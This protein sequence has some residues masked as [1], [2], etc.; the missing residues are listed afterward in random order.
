[1]FLP[2][3]NSCYTIAVPLIGYVYVPP[4]SVPTNV[5][6]AYVPPPDPQQLLAE[7]GIFLLQVFN[8]VQRQRT[9]TNFRSTL[10]S[11][12]YRDGYLY[13]AAVMG[14]RLFGTFLVSDPS[15]ASPASLP[16]VDHVPRSTCSAPLHSGSSAI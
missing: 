6:P 3:T 15:P 4:V 10:L 11:T 9:D 1:M 13:F 16:L 12:L 8:H 7:T 5:S 14:I 2:L